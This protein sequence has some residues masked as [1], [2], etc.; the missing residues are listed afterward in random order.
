MARNRQ[1]AKERQARRKAKEARG[2]K[3]RGGKATPPGGAERATEA[4]HGRDAPAREERSEER[5]SRE[6]PQARGAG[7]T[8]AR[9][10]DETPEAGSGA[11]GDADVD[12]GGNGRREDQL[13]DPHLQT[14]APP[15]D[16]GSSGEV[17]GYEQDLDS[18][19]DGPE[20]TDAAPD[21]PEEDLGD[22][23][24]G[25]RASA[26]KHKHRPR[27][28]QFLFAVWAELQRVQ[29]PDR[30]AL[31]TLTGVVLGFVLLAGGYLG[32]LDAIFSRIIQAIL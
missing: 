10:P 30:Q 11:A 32:L 14:G 28:V 21:M 20:R 18:S 6:A 4:E 29:W 31:T 5:E 23:S 19:S 3:A 1:R 27:F 25:R 13:I 26:E 7:E 8:A 12:P 15:Q 22:D 17:L 2:G 16:V 24:S 9:E